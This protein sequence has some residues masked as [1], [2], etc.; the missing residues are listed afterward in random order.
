MVL[1]PM[2]ISVWTYDLVGSVTTLHAVQ[3]LLWSLEFVTHDKYQALNDEVSAACVFQFSQLYL[4]TY[5]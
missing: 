3:T 4:D 2:I 1:W 5:N